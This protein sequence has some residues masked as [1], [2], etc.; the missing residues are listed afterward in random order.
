MGIRTL[1]RIFLFGAVNDVCFSKI[2]LNYFL[3]ATGV[4]VGCVV[5]GAVGPY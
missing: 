3:P 5:D 4:V 2:R 1:P